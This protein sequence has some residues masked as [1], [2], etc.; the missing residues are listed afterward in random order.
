M[1]NRLI[2]MLAVASVLFGL[3][4]WRPWLTEAMAPAQLGLLMLALVLGGLAYL[5]VAHALGVIEA[6]T[7]T[8]GIL[9]RVRRRRS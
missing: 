5:G 7:F 9:R 8:R 4:A 2:G 3:T 6:S 1:N